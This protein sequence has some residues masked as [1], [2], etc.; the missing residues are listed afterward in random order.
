MN[1]KRVIRPKDVDHVAGVTDLWT[2]GHNEIFCKSVSHP[3]KG[4]NGKTAHLATYSHER[5][6][7]N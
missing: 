3:L 1:R 6:N 5:L 2:D 4:V 7:H